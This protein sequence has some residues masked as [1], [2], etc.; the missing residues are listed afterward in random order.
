MLKEGRRGFET[1]APPLETNMVRENMSLLRS[2]SGP[3]SQ[4]YKHRTP[5]E[6]KTRS[7]Y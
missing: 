7:V 5:P 4:F 3:A 1:C 6:W 2:E